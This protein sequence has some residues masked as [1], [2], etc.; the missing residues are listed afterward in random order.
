MSEHAVAAAHL[1]DPSAGKIY[2]AIVAAVAR[3]ANIRTEAAFFVHLV[4]RTSFAEVHPRRAA[5]LLTI[6]SEAPIRSHR[7]RR[8]E[9]VDT[10]HF[11][12]EMRVEAPA[13]IDQE[14]I[15]WLQRAY[16][17]NVKGYSD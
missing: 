15:G 2:E 7:I 5:V 9:P 3:F 12:N 6:R 16:S 4:A 11:R 10:K 17:F 13:D 14:V 1:F 8:L